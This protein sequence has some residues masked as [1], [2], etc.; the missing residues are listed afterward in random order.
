MSLG[1]PSLPTG[2]DSQHDPPCCAPTTSP[3]CRLPLRVVSLWLRGTHRGE[4]A[5]GW[6]ARR[7]AQPRLCG[8]ICS[9][10]HREEPP[11]HRTAAC[12]PLPASLRPDASCPAA[13]HCMLCAS[14]AMCVLLLTTCCCAALPLLVQANG[15]ATTA[16][17]VW[18]RSEGS[19]WVRSRHCRSGG[20]DSGADPSTLSGL[21]THAHNLHLTQHMTDSRLTARLTDA[22]VHVPLTLDPGIASNHVIGDTL[23]LIMWTTHL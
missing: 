21:S 10:Q 8:S 9:G 7:M 2:D 6:V 4:P 15:T 14:A 16:G 11:A 18:A 12:T 19:D 3:A 5:Q 20:A 13:P 23:T 22:R 17:R 1:P